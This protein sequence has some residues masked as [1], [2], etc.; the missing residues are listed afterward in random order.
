MASLPLDLLRDAGVRL[1]AQVETNTASFTGAVTAL[2]SPGRND[3]E[4]ASIL[5]DLQH[6]SPASVPIG[7]DVASLASVQEGKT[8]AA[9][10]LDLGSSRRE[11][12]DGTAAV[13]ALHDLR[14]IFIRLDKV[15]KDDAHSTIASGAGDALERLNAVVHALALQALLNEAHASRERSWAWRTVH[16]E[17][18]ATLM[19]FAQTLPVRVLNAARQLASLIFLPLRHESDSHTLSSAATAPQP[20]NNT[21]EARRSINSTIALLKKQPAV[22][23]FA[24]FPWSITASQKLESKGL[25]VAPARSVAYRMGSAGIDLRSVIRPEDESIMGL[26]PYLTS[27]AQGTGFDAQVARSLSKATRE[28]R[29]I[30]LTPRSLA[31]LPL[32]LVRDEARAKERALQDHIRQLAMAIGSAATGL[33]DIGSAAL[34]A[35]GNPFA[36]T[37]GQAEQLEAL[38]LPPENAAQT[39][40]EGVSAP[41]AALNALENV[42]TTGLNIAGH[43]TAQT[44][45]AQSLG[46]YNAAPL[47]LST[48]AWWSRIWIKLFG[49]PLVGYMVYRFASNNRATIKSTLWGVWDTVKGLV[50]NWIYEPVSNFVC[51]LQ[52]GTANHGLTAPLSLESDQASLA[53]MVTDFA[54]DMGR[55][56]SAASITSN[57]TND[58]INEMTQRVKMGD[59]SPVMTVYEEQLKVRLLHGLKPC[60]LTR[61]SLPLKISSQARWCAPRSSRC[62]RRR[63]TLSSR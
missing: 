55:H 21:A 47:G 25:G 56:P 31:T 41:V 2:A 38:V 22:F 4:L 52:R 63:S 16:D 62:K 14:D 35:S 8:T 15:Q 58:Q 34:V 29:R 32:R 11:L 54:H 42:L 3:T 23:L 61:S 27:M 37:R 26:S 12:P 30:L 6:L 57:L 50:V 48:P 39:A 17:T 59:L 1:D 33:Q 45:A 40:E 60:K 19:Y 18:Q 51:T 28:M 7:Q 43:S 24:L 46:L 36:S 10:A 5:A 9:S 49:Y 44:T 53:R 13:E 20:G